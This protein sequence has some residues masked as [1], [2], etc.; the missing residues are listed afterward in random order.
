MSDS[1]S[2]SRSDSVPD[3]VFVTLDQFRGDTLSCAGHPVVHTPHLDALAAEGVRLGRHY[4]QAAPC[5][6]GR[7]SI[8]TGTYQFNH[9]VVGNGTPLDRG[10]DNV[11]HL[12]RRAGY[13]PALFGYTDQSVDP[14][15]VLD[16]RD[17]RLEHY[18]GVLPGF[19]PVLPLV[20]ELEPW[21]RWL[22]DRG[23]TLPDSVH[24]LLA[25]EPGR[26]A[27]HGLSA[28][29]TDRYLEWLGRQDGPVFAHLSYLRP[30]PPYAAAGEWSTRYDPSSTPPAVPAESDR[31]PLHDVLLTHPIVAAP[32]DPERLAQLRAQY[33]GMVSDV[34]HQ[35]G[36]IR[37]ALV[38][39]GRWDRTVVIVTS[40]HGEQLGDQGL[41]EKVGWFEPSYHVLG[42]VRDPR[43]RAAGTVVDR[44]TE[45]VDW[46]PTLCDVLDQPIPAQCDGLPLTPFLDGT[47]PSWWRQAAHWEFDW[48]ST[49]DPSQ[50]GG[51]PWDRRSARRHLAVHRDDRYAYVQFGN[52]DWRCYDLGDDPSW[53]TTVDD[54]SVAFELAR[55]MLQWR[56]EHTDRR[57]ADT[58]VDHGLVGQLPPGT[59]E[60]LRRVRDTSDHDRSP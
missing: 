2:D 40:D 11:A 34:D 42:I 58:L 55:S 17:T 15:D 39:L 47:D 28:F 13:E 36:R 54:P 37:D 51:W 29:L 3:V 48:R 53:R 35:L 24:E 25:T 26:P 5:A 57:L 21:R 50:L 43:R 31:H 41:I 45:N 56:S 44:F 8:Y 23:H 20:R 49:A 18:E 46:F 9:R 60:S 12:A 52:G 7:A 6:P 1:R 33:Y 22:E 19:D 16:P 4:S 38:R 27:E 14:R 59:P 10:W 30:H 32:T